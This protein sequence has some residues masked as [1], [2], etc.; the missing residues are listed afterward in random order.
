MQTHE[1][2]GK[3]ARACGVSD[4]KWAGEAVE[5]FRAYIWQHTDGQ[6][7]LHVFGERNERENRTF[8]GINRMIAQFNSALHGFLLRLFCE[9]STS[10]AGIFV[11]YV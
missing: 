3:S 11:R 4:E 9:C 1:I 2:T 7:L 5:R 10:Q 6:K 8:C